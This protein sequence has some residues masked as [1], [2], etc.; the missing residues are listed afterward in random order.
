VYDTWEATWFDSEGKDAA[1]RGDPQMIGAKVCLWNDLYTADSG[2]SVFDIFDRFKG[3]AALISEKTWYGEKRADQ[4]KEKFGEKVR[5]YT[6]KVPCVN[7]GRVVMSKTYLLCKYD[8]ESGL[9]DTS[10]NGYDAKAGENISLPFTGIGFPYCASFTLSVPEA[11]AEDMTLF[12]GKDGRLYIRKTD[13]KLIASRGVY[14][15]EFDYM[16]PAGKNVNLKISSDNRKTVLLAGNKYA[17]DAVNTREHRREDSTTFILPVEY[18][19]KCVKKLNVT[20]E[21]LDTTPFLANPNIAYRCKAEASEYLVNDGRFTADMAVD[22]VVNRSCQLQFS[23]KDDSWLLLDLGKIKSFNRFVITFSEHV[24]EYKI[25]VS[26]DGETW[27]EIYHLENESKGNETKDEISLPLTSARYV[28]YCQVK[29]W[30]CEGLKGYYSGGIE[31]FEIYGHDFSG[32]DL[33]VEKAEKAGICADKVK[34]L[35]EYIKRQ[36]VYTAVLEKLVSEIEKKLN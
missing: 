31:E 5:F 33:L 13:M 16:L 11:I 9:C 19:S 14:N 25:L 15:F 21:V 29:M 7:P 26:D 20:D 34:F 36:H 10:G 4:S 8:F 24:P 3:G 1:L 18:I 2:F 22:G 32:Y 23:P 12:G 27:R 30:Y 28:R 35:K 17:Y 6:K